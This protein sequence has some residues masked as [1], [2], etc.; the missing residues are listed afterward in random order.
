M[1]SVTN[2][3][4]MF[5]QASSFNQH[6]RIWSVDAAG[7]YSMFTNATQ[8]I[9]TYL[10]GVSANGFGDNPNPGL[11]SQSPNIIDDSNIWDLVNGIDGL[12]FRN[13]TRNTNYY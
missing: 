9:N 13:R 7:F 8:M 6:I 5:S 1:F 12:D 11:F 3:R 2:M 4:Y 10:A